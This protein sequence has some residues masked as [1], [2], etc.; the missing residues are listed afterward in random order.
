MSMIWLIHLLISLIAIGLV[1]GMVGAG[2]MWTVAVI[3]GIFE[4]SWK[5][6]HD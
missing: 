5:R 6:L 2:I 3:Y 1:I 4:W